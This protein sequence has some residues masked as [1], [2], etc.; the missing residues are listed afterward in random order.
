MVGIFCFLV[1][2]PIFLMLAQIWSYAQP[3]VTKG[4]NATDANQINNL[5]NSFFY[6][7]ADQIIVFIYFGCIMGIFLSA[8]W[9]SANPATFPIGL[10]FLIPLLLLSFPL[11]DISHAFYTNP[12][13]ANVAGHFTGTEYL[14]D[15]APWLTALVTVAYLLFLATR[16]QGAPGVPSGG[17]IVGG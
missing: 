2:L 17:N 7:S 6:N 14:S 3:S 5:G 16:K 15:N 8:L 1:L 10:L 11:A 9:E 13:F 12:G 4:L